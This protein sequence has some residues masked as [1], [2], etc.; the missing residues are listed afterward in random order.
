[1]GVGETTCETATYLKY[2]NANA[3]PVTGQAAWF[4][5]RVSIRKSDADVEQSAPQFAP[6]HFGE[7]D[8]RPLRYGAQLRE[9]TSRRSKQEGTR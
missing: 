3:D 9:R 8:Q 1:M 7:A 2:H 5:L 6:L 4:D